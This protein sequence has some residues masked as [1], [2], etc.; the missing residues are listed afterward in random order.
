MKMKYNIGITVKYLAAITS[1]HNG[2][3][4][5]QRFCILSNTHTVLLLLLTQLWQYLFSLAR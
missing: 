3:C 5:F 2:A 4:V 1:E